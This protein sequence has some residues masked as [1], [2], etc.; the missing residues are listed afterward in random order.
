MDKGRDFSPLW[1]KR[2]I[3]GQKLSSTKEGERREAEAAAG[4]EDPLPSRLGQKRSLLLPNRLTASRKRGQKRDG[5]GDMCTWP[6]QFLLTQLLF[7][8]PEGGRQQQVPPCSRRE[9]GSNESPALLKPSPA[10]PL[11]EWR[12]GKGSSDESWET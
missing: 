6:Q 5:L 3:L 12:E 10:P 2:L 9:G 1:E 11:E 4:E 8:L 7:S